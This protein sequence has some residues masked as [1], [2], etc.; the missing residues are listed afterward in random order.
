MDIPNIAAVS[1][2]AVVNAVLHSPEGQKAASFE[3]FLERIKDELFAEADRIESSLSSVDMLPCPL[4]SIFC[5]GP[6]HSARD[7]S[8]GGK[9]NNFG[10]HGTGFAPA[11]DSLTALKNAVFDE[12]LLSVA[13]LAAVCDENFKGRETLLAKIRNVY[14]KLGNDLDAADSL[15]ERLLAWFADSWDGRKNVRGGLYRP[16][17]GS[18][19]YYVRHPEEIPASPDGRLRSE[20]FPAN[21][22]PSLG[23]PVKGPLSVIR[24][25]TKPDLMRAVNGGPLT[26]ELSDSV[27]RTPEAVVK[28]AQ[29]VQYFA[30]R[31]GHQLQ[32]NTINREDLLDAKA[33]PE[34]WRHLIVRVWGWSGYFVELDA[35][36]QDQI[37]K[38][39]EMVF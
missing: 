32:I 5:D 4:T 35:P 38:R 15:A 33:H 14:P 13:E 25:F 18:A 27:F 31:G 20:P 29:A 19:M 9:Y 6:I 36:Y 30:E 39:A 1:F 2:P 22:A 3:E 21:Y 10:I 26:I 12:K 11:V 7:L 23:V 24:S 37:I 34:K 28:V 16:G 8:A 17:T